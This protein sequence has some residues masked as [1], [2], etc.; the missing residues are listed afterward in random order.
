VTPV[1]LAR[2]LATTVIFTIVLCDNSEEKTTKE[3]PP[4]LGSVGGGTVGN[5]SLCRFGIVGVES[6]NR[7]RLVAVEDERIGDVKQS[8]ASRRDVDVKGDVFFVF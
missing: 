6:R 8:V 2:V 3:K 5:A 7:R 4:R 1:F